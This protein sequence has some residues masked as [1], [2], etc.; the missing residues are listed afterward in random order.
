VENKYDIIPIAKN[1]VV[2]IRYIM[3]NSREEVLENR[4]NLDP[5]NYLHGSTGIQPLLQAQLEGLRVGDK[6]TVFLPAE[7]GLTG[8]DF[9]FEV[10]IDDVRSASSEEIMLGYPVKLTVQKCETEC[11][12]Y[13]Q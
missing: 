12:C 6:K 5:V 10:I 2:A 7:S 9:T 11:P 4:M 8:E 1:C 3:K 13:D